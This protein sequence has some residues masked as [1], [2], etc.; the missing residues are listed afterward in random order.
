MAP[1]AHI[2]VLFLRPIRALDALNFANFH[3]VRTCLWLT[4]ACP[5]FHQLPS[6]FQRVAATIGLFGF[7]TNDMRQ[8][9]LNHYRQ[10][11]PR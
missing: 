11:L 8:R 6:L 4:I 2:G 10:S 7:V 5:T 9:S 1:V 3:D